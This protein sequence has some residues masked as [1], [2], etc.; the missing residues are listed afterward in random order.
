MF[1]DLD[2]SLIQTK[3]KI[4]ENAVTSLGAT[5]RDGNALS[6]ITQSQQLLLSMFKQQ[7]A[8]IIPVT[9]RNTDAL[10]RVNYDF[11]DY[12]VV[13]HGA[14][15]L[16]KCNSVCQQWL[17]QIDH[18][19]AKWPQLLEDCNKEI[20]GII[21]SLG[22]DARTRVI[23]DQDIPAYVSVKGQEDALARISEHSECAKLFTRHANGRNHAMLPPYA[24]K[25]DAVEFMKTQM[26]LTV[27]DL[28]IGIGD[29]HSDLN[30]MQS[31]QFAMLPTTS[32]IAAG[33]F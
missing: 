27:N 17:T 25:K 16:T 4:P 22:L 24:S 28:T 21:D 5:D 9:G 8:T 15:V 12:R 31:C 19:L 23:I 2:D 7:G 32:Q 26:Q 3:R 30:F 20:L 11:D 10:D 14:V 33:L 18:H 29:S 6:F 13:S 1:T